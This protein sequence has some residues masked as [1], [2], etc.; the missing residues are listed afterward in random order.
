MNNYP[1]TIFDSI[2]DWMNSAVEKGLDDYS[3]TFPPTDIFLDEDD[4]LVFG[5]AVAGFEPEDIEVTFSGD[6]LQISSHI[7]EEKEEKRKRIKKILK[8]RI[9]R[10][11]F[12]SKYS[13]APGKFDAE[14][15]TAT[16]K[17]GVLTVTIPRSE[18][19]KPRKVK[20]S[21]N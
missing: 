9:A 10:R 14:K 1:T 5:F 16:H 19:S 11:N 3:S 8:H 18:N 21:V 13:L 2:F 4:S 6:C 7:S 20:I 17:N 15:A 12:D